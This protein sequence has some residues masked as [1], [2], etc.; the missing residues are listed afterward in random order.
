MAI[1]A[2]DPFGADDDD[3]FASPPFEISPKQID[4]SDS[5]NPFDTTFSCGPLTNLDPPPPPPLP[6]NRSA[7]LRQRSSVPQAGIQTSPNVD[8]MQSGGNRSVDI[9]KSNSSQHALV[10]DDIQRLVHSFPAMALNGN[11]KNDFSS[12][13]RFHSHEFDENISNESKSRVVNAK[14]NNDNSGESLVSQGNAAQYVTLAQKRP[15][16]EEVVFTLSEEMSTIHNSKT[17]QYTLSVRGILSVRDFSFI[18]KSF[19]NQY[20]INVNSNFVLKIR[21]KGAIIPFWNDSSK[22]SLECRL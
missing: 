21:N 12:S 15:P 16:S 13:R 6:S 4:F 9:N 17:K 7:A 3:D 10:D 1:E 8:H 11:T 2:F 5:S 22:S 19:I 20:L 18:L 14:T